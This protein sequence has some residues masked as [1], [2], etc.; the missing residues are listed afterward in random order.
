M[1]R[2]GYWPGLVLLVFA[3]A[4]AVAQ[5]LSLVTGAVAPP[6]TLGSLWAAVSANSLVGF[7]ALVEQ[8]LSPSLWPPILWLLLLPAWAPVGLLGLLLLLVGRGRGHGRD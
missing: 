5:L 3:A 7:Q 6:V 1:G 2:V 8:S 4:T